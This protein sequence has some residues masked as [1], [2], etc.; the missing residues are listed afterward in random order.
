[1]IFS[2]FRARPLRALE[3]EWTLATKLF[4]FVTQGLPIG[5]IFSLL[6]AFLIFKRCRGRIEIAPDCARCGLTDTRNLARRVR[7]PADSF[8]QQLSR[9]QF[10]E[11]EVYEPGR[12]R[13]AEITPLD[14]PLNHRPVLVS[15][16][17][18]SADQIPQRK[19]I[20]RFSVGIR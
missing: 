10:T 5:T 16:S 9:S 15:L 20:D 19:H 11:P 3:I 8:N 6:L 17:P 14:K 7:I 13:I 2:N 12:R 18:F 4:E 1:M